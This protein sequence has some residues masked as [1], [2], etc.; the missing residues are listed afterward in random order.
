MKSYKW[1]IG[2][3]AGI[4]FSTALLYKIYSIQKEK[5]WSDMYVREIL[6][7][8]IITVKHKQRNSDV[9]NSDDEI[10]SDPDSKDISDCE[11]SMIDI[12]RDWPISLSKNNRA[13]RKSKIQYKNFNSKLKESPKSTMDTLFYK[14]CKCYVESRHDK[15]P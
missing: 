10:L 12:K 4:L 14:I 8:D 3:G 11:K 13:D 7:D 6:D 15:S 5:E 1:I 2:A 9:V